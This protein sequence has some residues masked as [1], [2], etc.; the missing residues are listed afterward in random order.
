MKVYY[1]FLIITLINIWYAIIH[2]QELPP[3]QSYPPETYL[4]DHQNWSIAQTENNFIYIANNKGLLEFNGE[5]WQLYESPNGKMRSVKVI[6]NLIYTGCYREFGYW[7]K[8]NFGYLKYHSLSQALNVEFLEDEEFWNILSLDNWILFQSLKRIYI[9]NKKDQSYSVINS[10]SIIYK[11]FKVNKTIYFQKA[12]DGLYKIENAIPT[13]VSNH[14]VLKENYLVNI[15]SLNKNLLIQTEEQGFYVLQPNNKLTQWNT[16]SNQFITNLSVYRSKQLKDG[17]IVFGTRSNGIY[18]I[19]TEGTINYSLNYSNG[20]LSNT[21]HDIF[22]DSENN[23]WLA[24]ENGIN[25][26]NIKSPFYIYH[27]DEGRL[28]TVY[29]SIIHNG[30]LYLGTNQGLFYKSLQNSNATFKFIEG[31]EGP[32][33]CLTNYKNTLFCGH[34]LGTFIINNDKIIKRIDTN[35][36]WNL[37]PI[38]N[39]PNLL[40]Q[41]NYNGLSVIE[42]KNGNWYFKNKIEGFKTSSKFF[43]ILDQTIFISH[44]YKGVYKLKVDTSFTKVIKVLKD[45]T[46]N[47]GSYSSL[48]KYNNKL[49]YTYKDGVFGYNKEQ[50]KFIKDSIISPFFEKDQFTSGKLVS[51][52][53]NNILWG[54]SKNKLNYI[55]PGKLSKEPNILGIPYSQSLPHA[56]SGLENISYLYDQKYLIGTTDGYIVLDI[57]KI[58]N[59]KQNITIN[60][61]LVS[62]ISNEEVHY[63]DL[64]SKVTFKNKH[65]NIQFNFSVP[66]YSKYLDIEYQYKLEGFHSNWSK[67]SQKSNILFK[68]LPFGD[69]EFHVKS[70]ISNTVAKNKVTY[71]FTIAKPWFLSEIMIMIYVIIALL[72]IILTHNIYKRYYRK[73]KEKLILKTSR[74]LELKELEN[75]QQLMRFKNE[76]LR[77][78]IESKNR[79]LGISTMNLIKKNEFLGKIK[80]ELQNVKDISKLKRVINLID[81]SLNNTDDW[82]LFQEAFNNADKDFLKKI[83]AL[84]PSLTSNDLRLCAYLRL[85]L[86]SKE[87]APLLNIS[88]RSVEVKRYRLRKKLNLSRDSSLTDYILEI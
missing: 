64:N 18:H 85:N 75:K 68:N 6:D 31:T 30:L 82:N 17:S 11:I 19:T 32:V 5:Q 3:I 56:L 27:D 77:E 45:T 65:N 69:Y 48:I 63:A 81:K 37:I 24:L 43:E 78:D 55:T 52:N 76:K 58:K 79:E 57:D 2:A 42:N 70:R 40:L 47:K 83:K 16:P 87:I 60:S 10:N 84:H 46:V 39:K 14:P 73:Q 51:D 86:T 20:L 21:V 53:K 25:S 49:L 13:L 8:K 35:G 34:N 15:F 74:E 88:P 36:T 41:G 9:Y 26:I 66:E 80:K 33:W 38:P 62:D 44:E 67:W 4:A 23:I 22:E 72:L 1:R 28:G 54:F 71:K 50:N 59:T 7:Q 29:A 12:K 61:I